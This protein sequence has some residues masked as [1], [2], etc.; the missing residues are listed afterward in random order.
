V[1]ATIVTQNSSTAQFFFLVAAIAAGLGIIVG[2][3]D[4]GWV[5]WNI[6]LAVIVLCLSLGL[7]FFA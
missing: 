2:I 1:L 5:Y 4:R 7:L 6:L 3:V